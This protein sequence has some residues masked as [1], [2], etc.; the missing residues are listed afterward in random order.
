MF[1]FFLFPVSAASI[2]LPG[3]TSCFISWNIE[4]SVILLYIT[5]LRR[6]GKHFPCFNRIIESRVEVWES[7]K[8]YENK[9]SY[10][11]VSTIFPC[12]PKL[13]RVIETQLLVGVTV[14]AFHGCLSSPIIKFTATLDH[15]I[16]LCR[17][18]L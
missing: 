2:L 1:I 8:C 11:T 3:V 12:S 10:A 14:C 5:S 18:S 13:A 6:Y 17:K 16:Y 9:K 4:V 15:I 7:K